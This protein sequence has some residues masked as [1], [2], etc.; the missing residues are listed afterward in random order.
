MECKWCPVQK[1]IILW[2]I[3]WYVAYPITYRQLE[4]RMG[5]RGVSVDHSTLNRWV[6]RYAPEIEKQFRRRLCAVGKSWRFDETSIRVK[7]QWHYW[8][9][10]V[11]R[12]GQPGDFLLTPQ[13]N[14]ASAEAFLPKMMRLPGVPEK[15]TID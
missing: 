5:E 9:R 4:A 8:Y 14:R 12:D 7:G 6:I 3:R 2:G 15:I 1:E 10:A 11:D 13:C